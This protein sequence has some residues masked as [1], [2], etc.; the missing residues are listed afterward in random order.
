MTDPTF[1]RFDTADVLILQVE[2]DPDYDGAGELVNLIEN[3]DGELG[4]WG[5][6]S[7]EP[8]TYDVGISRTQVDGLWYLVMEPRVDQVN[9][10]WSEPQPVNPAWRIAA[11]YD[12]YHDPDEDGANWTRGRIQFLDEDQAVIS[13]S[14]VGD[15]KP[16]GAHR[17]PDLPI[18]DDAIFAR[19]SIS[20]AKNSDGDQVTN[21][22]AELWLRNIKLIQAPHHA[23]LAHPLPDVPA[24]Y[25]DD[26]IELAQGITIN[27]APLDANTMTLT[28]MAEGA[29]APVAGG[30]GYGREAYGMTFYGGTPDN[31]IALD[32][33]SLR[34]GKNVRLLTRTGEGYGPTFPLFTGEVA[35][36]RVDYDL[37]QPEGRRAKITLNCVDAAARMA[38]KRHTDIYADTWFARAYMEG[39]GVPWYVLFSPDLPVAVGVAATS[40]GTVLDQ[41]IKTR[42]SNQDDRIW[43][44][45]DGI[46]KAYH[47]DDV[48]ASVLVPMTDAIY[49][50][51][52]VASY[53]TDRVINSIKVTLLHG[54]SS[55][56]YGPYERPASIG[57]WG[58]RTG[59]YTIVNTDE[60]NPAEARAAARAILDRTADAAMVIE[61]ATVPILHAPGAYDWSFGSVYW[62]TLD[63]FAK[64]TVTNESPSFSYDLEV[65][66]IRHDISHHKWLT[67]YTFGAPD[68]PA[69]PT[70]PSSR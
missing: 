18:P 27:R 32:G 66:G 23:D 61:S 44:S 2:R 30:G 65:I 17:I 48:P 25:M 14:P 49:N 68:R 31:V 12:S 1:Q 57:K 56:D 34:P 41:L 40:D 5:W 52:L 33:S 63:L 4:A 67:T 46:L 16:N 64:V 53:D 36:G 26:V 70:R 35:Q 9:Y 15:W 58:R 51:N 47:K 45:A 11:S 43:V 13:S 55:T 8:L 7:P 29:D 6:I 39:L 20:A 3:P 10:I 38:A 37:T 50:G 21:E 19:L 22:D 24:H 28:L 62:A 60:W 59:T 54:D 69:A 42:D